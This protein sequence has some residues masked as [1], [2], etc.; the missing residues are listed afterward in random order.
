M[1]TNQQPEQLAIFGDD[2]AEAPRLRRFIGRCKV[3]RT[4]QAVEVADGNAWRYGRGCC[5]KSVQLV[6][7]Q[8]GYK[9]SRRCDSRCTH[10]TSSHCE[11]QCEGANHGKW[12]A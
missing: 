11:C 3:C 9:A 5:G 8:G 12:F 6:A 2:S 1:T 4:V 7:V 10:A